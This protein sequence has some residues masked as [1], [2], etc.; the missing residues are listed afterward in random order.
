MYRICSRF[1]SIDEI[2]KSDVELSSIFTE[3]CLDEDLLHTIDCCLGEVFKPWQEWV[4]LIIYSSNFFHIHTFNPPANSS[5]TT[6]K[7]PINCGTTSGK[8]SSS[9]QQDWGT[10]IC[11][12]CSPTT[13]LAFSSHT[14]RT[15]CIASAHHRCHRR[16]SCLTMKKRKWNFSRKSVKFS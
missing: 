5:P 13:F 12:N 1:R 8:A 15:R 6:K 2:D 11:R 14:L 3:S 7:S 10:S 16:N 9:W 4:M